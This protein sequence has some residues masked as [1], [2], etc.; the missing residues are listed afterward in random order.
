MAKRSRFLL[1]HQILLTLFSVC[2]LILF[3]TSMLR[4]NEKNNDIVQISNQQLKS[5][6][7]SSIDFFERQYTIPIT[8]ELVR[9]SKSIVVNDYLTAPSNE[10][11][12]IRP[13]IEKYLSNIAKDDL[14]YI[15]IFSLT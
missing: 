3:V 12:I 10:R 2:F 15:S 11:I 9:I 6:M 4:F 13:E 8:K 1:L 5:N 14:K 7:Q